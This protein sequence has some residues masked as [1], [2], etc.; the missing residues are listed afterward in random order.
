MRRTLGEIDSKSSQ[1]KNE[2]IIIGLDIAVSIQ[3]SAVQSFLARWLEL[4]SVEPSSCSVSTMIA[5]IGLDTAKMA[6]AV[7]VMV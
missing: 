7:G 1:A 3:Y 4:V 5:A 6:T 2:G